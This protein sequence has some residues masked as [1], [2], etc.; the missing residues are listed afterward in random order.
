MFS[1]RAR[2]QGVGVVDDFNRYPIFKDRNPGFSSR[3]GSTSAVMA[4]LL[5]LACQHGGGKR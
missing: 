2:T 3:G 4:E 5:G 1:R